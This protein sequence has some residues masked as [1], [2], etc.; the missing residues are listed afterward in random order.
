MSNEINCGSVFFYL[1][2][3]ENIFYLVWLIN[4]FWWHIDLKIKN[5]IVSCMK[6]F[7]FFP[8]LFS[9]FWLFFFKLSPQ[10]LTFSMN[11]FSRF[12]LFVQA[13]SQIFLIF[14]DFF[15][16]K[17]WLYSH[18]FLFEIFFFFPE[19]EEKL[20]FSSVKLSK[21]EKVFFFLKVS[22]F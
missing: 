10:I 17:F 13:L 15:F 2:P 9:R 22:F 11:F 16:S 3:H 4:C 14:A 21:V 20:F 19:K 8:S 12:W 5:K 1:V 7:D 6:C 18:N